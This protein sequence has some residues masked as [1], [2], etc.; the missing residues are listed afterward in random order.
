MEIGA[1]E[2]AVAEFDH[3]SDDDYVD[4]RRL[5]VVIDRL[6]A[7]LCRVVHRA[8]ER[9]DHLVTGQTPTSFV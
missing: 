7:K 3:G 8:Q 6:Q 4:P 2:A 1:L 5:S 9:G